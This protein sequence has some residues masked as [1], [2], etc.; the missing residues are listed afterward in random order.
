MV[1]LILSLNTFGQKGVIKG[2]LIDFNT[3]QPITEAPIIL[4]G[5]TLGVQS[6]TEGQFVFDK[7]KYLDIELIVHGQSVLF[8]GTG[9][10]TAQKNNYYTLILRN[11]CLS[12]ENKVIDLGILYMVNIGDEKRFDELPC[13]EIDNK[14]FK[15]QLVD[16]AERYI[17]GKMGLMDFKTPSEDCKNE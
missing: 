15:Y 5:T 2:K 3:N 13:K 1:T 11:L 8:F 9:E 6:D 7:L 10:K 17:N 4:Y 14:R 12:K 16:G